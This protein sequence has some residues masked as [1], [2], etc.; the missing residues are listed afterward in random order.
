MKVIDRN[1]L[2]GNMT[3]KKKL[4]N[5]IQRLYASAQAAKAVKAARRKAGVTC[6]LCNASIPNGFLV[7]HKASV[8]GENQ[9]SLAPPL[10]HNPNSWVSVVSGGLPSLGKRR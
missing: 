2:A 8:H 10:P 4:H 7:H 6:I 9:V 5:E 1:K 3:R